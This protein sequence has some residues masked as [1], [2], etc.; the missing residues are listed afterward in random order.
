M[1]E[2]MVAM[3]LVLIGLLGILGLILKSM[4]VDKNV[5]TQFIA[6]YLASEGVE[7]VKNIIDTDQALYLQGQATSWNATMQSG[8]YEVRYDTDKDTLVNLGG[9]TSTKPL[10]FDEASG[11]YGYGG[12]NPTVFTRTIRVEG[13]SNEIAVDSIVGWNEDGREKELKVSDVFTNWRAPN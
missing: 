13:S 11:I 1:I 2:S 12:G 6:S 5:R 4:H 10:L 8:S 3:S 9:A 7:V